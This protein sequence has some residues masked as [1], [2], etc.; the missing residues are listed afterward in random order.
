MKV[1]LLFAPLV[2]ILILSACKHD[3][4]VVPENPGGQPGD[5]IV[6]CDPDTVYFQN[7]VLPLLVSSCGVAGCHDA[8]SANDGVVLVDYASVIRTG[9]I[10]PGKP[11]DSDLYEVLVDDD[12]EDR[13]PPV[14]RQA[15]TA[16]QIAKIRK[17]ISQGA[18]NNACESNSCDSFNISFQAHVLPVIQNSCTG[19]HSG[20]A[21]SGGIS[22][23]NHAQIAASASGGRLLGAVR[24]D[25]GFSPMP[26]S[27]NKLSDC[28]ITQIKKW[29]ENGTP[30]N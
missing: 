19:C 18:K 2:T 27:G 15:L 29:I 22:L 25:P 21:P 26:Q 8:A 10:E 4:G 14:D 7:E 5:T 1:K 6:L 17:W 24:H 23:T 13:M 9:K 20:G 16:E 11:D 30:N 28:Q 3:P 12:P